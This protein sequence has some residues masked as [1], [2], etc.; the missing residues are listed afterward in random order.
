[1]N[2]GWRHVQGAV[3]FDADVNENEDTYPVELRE[4]RIRSPLVITA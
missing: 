2:R 4:T 3:N 1:M